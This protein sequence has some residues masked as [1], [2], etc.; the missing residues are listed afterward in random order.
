MTPR[1]AILAAV[2]ALACATALAGT[3]GIST[4]HADTTPTCAQV[5]AA[6]PQTGHTM[7]PAAPAMFAADFPVINDC[8]WGYPLGGFGGISKGYP[9]TH[10]PIVFVHGNQVDA[11]NWFLVADQFRQAGYTNQELWAVS[12]NGLENAY[13]GMPTCCQPASESTA[14]WQSTS[15]PGYALCCNGGHGGSDDPNVPDVYAFI[16]AVQAYTGSQQVDIVAHSLGGTIVRKLLNDHPDLRADVPAVVLIATANHGTTV[17]RGLDT[18]YYGCDEIAPGTPWLADLNSQGE[19]VGPTHWMSIYN[20]A[21]NADPFFQAAPGVFDDT[22]SPHLAGA[23]YNISCPKTYHN[24]LRVRP[25]I[26]S[27]YLG[28][29]LADGQAAPSTPAPAVTVSSMCTV[30]DQ[31]PGTN[32]PEAPGATLLLVPAVAGLAVGALRR[33]RHRTVAV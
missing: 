15:P 24:D 30:V 11:E 17:C 18:S 23:D 21:D 26:V 32:L 9:L 5:A 6:E 1:R 4:A 28:F 7:P 31:N 2:A 14:Y 8:E 27:M 19:A 10:T 13:A 33:R 16:K 25:D 20:G 3:G 12:Y 29:L 22:Q